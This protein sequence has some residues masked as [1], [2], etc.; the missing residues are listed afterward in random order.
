M[1]FPSLLCVLAF[2]ITTISSCK[3]NIVRLQCQAWPGLISC[4]D[5]EINKYCNGDSSSVTSLTFNRQDITTLPSGIFADMISL[6]HLDIG[7]NKI[8][9][10]NGFVFQGLTSLSNLNMA[11]ND[12]QTISGAAFWS[13]S[14]S[15]TRVDMAFNGLTD[16]PSILFNG[17]N[18]LTSVDLSYNK[19]TA[20]RGDLF[21]TQKSKIS[22]L[23][24]IDLRGNE[25]SALPADIF[26]DL[27]ALRQL[28]LNLNPAHGRK[29]LDCNTNVVKMPPYKEGSCRQVAPGIAYYIGGDVGYIQD[30]SWGYVVSEH[31]HPGPR[32][33]VTAVSGTVSTNATA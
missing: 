28:F 17:L 23:N 19:I 15:L 16:I 11:Q 30:G 29:Y 8:R 20:L 13:Q 14:N 5:D 1:K 25:I 6:T 33:N 24:M 10:I 9:E 7:D 4:L 27:A 31:A 3:I 21:T 18:E 22:S 2:S 12:I 26:T 32:A